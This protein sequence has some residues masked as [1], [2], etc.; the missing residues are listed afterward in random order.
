MLEK[1]D[2]VAP[3]LVLALLG[4]LCHSVMSS[5]AMSKAQ[6]KDEPLITE[7]MLRPD[8]LAPEPRASPINRDPFEVRWASYRDGSGLGSSETPGD[9][10]A[11]ATTSPYTPESD[12]GP[13]PLPSGLKGLLLGDEGQY[14]VVGDRICRPGDLVSGDD[15]RRSWVVERVDVD[16]V[17]LRF[18]DTLRKIEL[19][20]TDKAPAPSTSAPSEDTEP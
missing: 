9:Q 18:G 16:G 17:V 1:I 8:L 14:V 11:T 6:G 13:P 3:Y 15:P 7:K 20:S 10:S 12:E 2:K 4:Y 5:G 19:T